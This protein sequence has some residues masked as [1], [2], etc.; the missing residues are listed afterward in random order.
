MSDLE[1]AWSDA[2]RTTSDYA[3]TH[4]NLME[5]LTAWIADNVSVEVIITG[6]PPD[7]QV[8]LQMVLTTKRKGL[9]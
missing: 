3:P 7:V 1:K 6:E 4:E 5:C 8:G 9:E 2:V